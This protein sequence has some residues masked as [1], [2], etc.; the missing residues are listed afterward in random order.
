ML[1]DE[2]THYLTVA[3]QHPICRARFER[4]VCGFD[5]NDMKRIQCVDLALIQNYLPQ[6]NSD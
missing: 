4:K 1:R 5:E 2:K 6:L 3:T